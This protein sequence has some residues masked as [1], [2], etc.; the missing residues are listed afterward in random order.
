MWYHVAVCVPVGWSASAGGASAGTGRCC[1]TWWSGCR[2]GPSVTSADGR[3]S[4]TLLPTH[5]THETWAKHNTHIQ[6]MKHGQNTIH[7]HTVSVRLR[8]ENLIV[9]FMHILLLNLYLHIY[10]LVGWLLLFKDD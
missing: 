9:F 7:T 2:T 5:T 10:K 3:G 1:R 4:P 8:L 6:P